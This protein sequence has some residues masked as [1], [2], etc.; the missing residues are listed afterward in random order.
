MPLLFRSIQI[1]C[2]GL[3][4][5]FLLH[6]F[7]TFGLWIDAG[8]IWAWKEVWIGMMAVLALFF[9]FKQKTRQ[10]LF[11][12]KI[13]LLFV[14]LF[15]SGIVLTLFINSYIVHA[16]FARRAMAM[17]YD[18]LGFFLLLL[19]S[20]LGLVSW[21]SSTEKL[22]LRYGRVMKWCLFFALILWCVVAIKPWTMK[23][24]GFNNYVFEGTVGMQPP[25]VYYTHI[26]Y[27]LPRSQFL[28]ERPTTYGFWLTAFFP[29]FFMLFLRRRPVSQ[30][31][32]R[33]TIYGLNI[34]L[35]F[36]RAAW[37]SWIIIV[38]VL[39]GLTA[40]IPRKKLLCIYGLP[41]LLL[42]GTILA[43]GRQQIAM[44]GY[45]NYGH[46]TMVKKGLAMLVEKP[47]RWWWWA[48][49]WPWSHRDGGLAFN[50][51]NQF[52]QILIEFGKIGALPRLSLWWLSLYVGYYYR[53]YRNDDA[54]PYLLAF[55][56]WMVTL[57]ISGMVLHSF[58]DRMVVYPFMLLFGLALWMSLY[59]SD[60]P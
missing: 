5:H 3:M 50:P 8:A 26:N 25:A 2:V 6:T 58:A 45:S 15:V 21:T 56:L 4:V 40:K 34:I 32:W 1:F 16:S 42:F 38:V 46:M 28:F 20:A 37:G 44:R 9:L 39:I 60:S 11:S 57:S 47:L 31:R 27:G 12:S 14:W 10:T 53:I 43:L 30:T 33:W 22:L 13:F 49:V 55:S 51:E 29:L 59:R 54:A 36:S 19:G 17:R 23:L 48:S 7:V 18:Y 41:L 24:F 35:T 52:L